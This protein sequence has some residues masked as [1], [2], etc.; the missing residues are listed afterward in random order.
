MKTT[1]LEVIAAA[2]AIAALAAI[3]VGCWHTSV[4]NSPGILAGFLGAIVLGFLACFVAE[5]A[6]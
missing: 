1:I 6:G 4:H 3:P 5:I 2:I